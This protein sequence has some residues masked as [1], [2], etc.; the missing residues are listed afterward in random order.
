MM[1]SF[2]QMQAINL[3]RVSRSI[4]NQHENFVVNYVN[5][6]CLR[7]AVFTGTYPW[8]YHPASDELFMILEGEICIDFQDRDTV[9]LKPNDIFTIP[10]G[11][12]HR[13]RATQRAVN[14]C[15]EQSGATTEFLEGQ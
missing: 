3:Y 12:I 14:I 15:F 9:T 8:H 10:A 4:S 2:E 13:T 11:V 1:Q 5:E 6:C 7:L